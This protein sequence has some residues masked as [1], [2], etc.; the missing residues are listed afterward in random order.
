[1]KTTFTHHVTNA[2]AFGWRVA[3]RLTQGAQALPND[4]CE[5]LRVARQ[6]AVAARK[7]PVLES[8]PRLAW[9]GAHGDLGDRQPSLWS[10]VAAAMPLVVLVAGLVAI[11]IVQSDRR[12]VEVAEVDAALLTDTLP[13]AAYTDPGFAVFLRLER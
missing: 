4:I 2:D 5:R 10:R 1:M 11:S 8:A 3:A 13:P 7:H 6:Q 9:S 12:A